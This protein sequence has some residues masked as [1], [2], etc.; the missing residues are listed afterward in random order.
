MKTGGASADIV[1][2]SAGVILERGEE[3]MLSDAE[4]S[5]PELHKA[6]QVESMPTE[7]HR[8]E[9]DHNQAATPKLQRRWRAV[10]TELMAFLA[11]VAAIVAIMI[12]HRDAEKLFG[13]FEAI[14][15]QII[16]EGNKIKAPKGPV[17]VQFWTP[18]PRT[19]EAADVK[20]WE[21]VESDARLDAFA[22]RLVKA[23]LIAGY[24]RYEIV[25]AGR[26]TRRPG[27]WWVSTNEAGFNLAD[28][29]R[30]YQDFWK[31]GDDKVYMEIQPIGS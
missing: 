6:D 24:R 28:F 26:G 18:S 3:L 15:P 16:F 22:D 2:A 4:A 14:G 27:A 7:P 21:K 23:Q 12:A 8:R 30:V 11:L 29:L 31:P 20:E 17:Q 19:N 9:P 13:M 10:A 1:R 5:H 25:G